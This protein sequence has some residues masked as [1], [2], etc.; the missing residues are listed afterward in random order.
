MV[1]PI[2]FFHLFPVFSSS[3]HL[4]ELMGTYSRLVKATEVMEAK[5]T[6]MIPPRIGSGIVEKNAV[7]LPKMP[8]TSIKMPA[9]WG[10]EGKWI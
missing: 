2:L 10:R 4:E 9:V 3:S 5:R 6:N 8:N 7:N 1:F